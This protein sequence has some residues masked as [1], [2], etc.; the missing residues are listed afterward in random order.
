VQ[1][2]A[3]SVHQAW[4]PR[5]APYAAVSNRKLPHISTN[6][7]PGPFKRSDE[8]LAHMLNRCRPVMRHAH[9][10]TAA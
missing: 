9:A 6:V 1:H 5:K 2:Q 8:G 4:M 10:C 3:A 7:Q